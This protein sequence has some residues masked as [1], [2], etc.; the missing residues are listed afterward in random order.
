MLGSG[1]SPAPDTMLREI[2]QSQKDKEHMTPLCVESKTMDYTEPGNGSVVGEWRVWQM[3]V[4]G[5]KV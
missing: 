2:S 4:K 3:F 1:V 5:Y